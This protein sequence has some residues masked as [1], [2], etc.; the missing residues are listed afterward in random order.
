MFGWPVFG[1]RRVSGGV[2]SSGGVSAASGVTTAT[3]SSGGVFTTGSTRSGVGVLGLSATFGSPLDF[4]ANRI[5]TTSATAPAAPPIHS[6][7]FFEPPTIRCE[8]VVTDRWC[9]ASSNI[10]AC[11]I[12]AGGIG[13]DSA[14][15]GA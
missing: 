5:T 2:M 15:G 14:I 7:G 1:W 10:G 12:G 9:C 11:G 8:S 3:R 6:S 13:A 4:I